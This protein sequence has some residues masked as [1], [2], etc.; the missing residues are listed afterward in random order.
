MA[1]K[2]STTGATFA[3]VSNNLKLKGGVFGL[4][5]GYNWQTNWAV[6]GAETDI[7]WTGARGSG[8]FVCPTACS[9][10]GAVTAIL[11]PKLAWFGTLRNRVGITASSFLAYVTGGLAYGGIK[12]DGTF[13]GFNIAAQ[14]VSGNLQLPSS[15]RVGWTIG[16]GIETVLAGNWTAKIEY[17]HVDLGSFTVVS[18]VVAGGFSFKIA[19]DI[20]RIGVNY[21]LH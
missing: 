2:D 18:P 13:S 1:F 6:F 7:Q 9:P 20:V 8:S 3:T 19:D 4:H 21:Q 16:V 10:N 14:P 17:L 11:D 5:A 12:S 15:T